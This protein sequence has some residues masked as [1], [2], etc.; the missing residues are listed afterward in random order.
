MDVFTDVNPLFVIN[1]ESGWYEGWMIH[2]ITV[3]AVAAPR[4][5]GHAQFGMLTERDAQMLKGM[6]TGNNVPGNIFTVDGRAPHF[7]KVSDHFPDVQTNVVPLHVS[8][9]AYNAMQQSDAHSYWE[10]QLPRD[11]L[12][13]PALRVTDY[14]RTSGRF[15]QGS[16]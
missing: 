15:R 1:N 14:R 16:R 8:M 10:V 7:P 3:P 9:G 4:P 6:G 2:D 5:D 11:E 12:G 13:A